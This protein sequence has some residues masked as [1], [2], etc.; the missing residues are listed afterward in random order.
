MTAFELAVL[1]QRRSYGPLVWRDPNSES[2]Q[3]NFKPPSRQGPILLDPVRLHLFHS[4][5]SITFTPKKPGSRGCTDITGPTWML[6]DDVVSRPNTWG[7]T[8]VWFW[9]DNFYLGTCPLGL[10]LALVIR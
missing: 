1:I 6:K 10:G 8:G 3:Y 4:S 5:F 9:V 7:Y 2:L